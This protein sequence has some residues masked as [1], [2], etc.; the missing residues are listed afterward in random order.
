MSK[1]I[2]YLDHAAATP[3]DERVFR[4]MEPYFADHFYNP[5]AAYAPAREVRAD[6]ED[7]RHRLAIVIGAKKDEIILTAGATES[8][9]LAIHGLLAGGGHA[10][11][12]ATEH[13]AV[14]QA[15]QPY[16]HNIAPADPRGIITPEAVSSA[17][18]DETV[19]VS[20]TAADSELGTVQSL[21]KIA[22]AIE[23]IRSDR[24][25]RGVKTPLYFH[26]DASQVAG[27][28]DIHVSRLGVDMLS[29][30]A[31]KCYGPKQV[32]LLWLRSHIQLEPIVRGGGQE[33]GLRAG[34]EYVAGAVGF[35]TALENAQAERHKEGARLA[36]LRDKLQ[37]ALTNEIPELVVNGHPKRRLP[38]HLH[39]SLDGLD[40]E[41][42]IFRLDEDGIL[43]ATGAACAANKNTRSSVLEAIGLADTLSDGSLRFTL[44]KLVDEEMI[45]RAVPTIIRAIR[46]EAAR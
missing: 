10:V 17:V 11:I 44:G 8:V 40:A 28:I 19:L 6:L 41:R 45:D 33:R 12:G 2:I 35:A 15:V 5:S 21:Q 20:I 13:Q 22:A 37:H 26:S 9:N 46:E 32:G 23:G 38:G 18:I 25:A 3:L 7:A 24:R 29:L 14:T 42:V 36:E 16:S 1:P 39:V 27:V 43:A 34:T 31:A 4:V 30:N